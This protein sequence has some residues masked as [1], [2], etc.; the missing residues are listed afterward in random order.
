MEEGSVG[1]RIDFQRNK[2]M[3]CTFQ[4]MSLNSNHPRRIFW[5]ASVE[6]SLETSKRVLPLHYR[7]LFSRGFRVQIKSCLVSDQARKENCKTLSKKTPKLSLS[8]SFP[9]SFSPT[10]SLSFR[11]FLSPS[12]SLSLPPVFFH[13]HHHRNSLTTINTNLF[14]WNKNCPVLLSPSPPLLR[15]RFAVFL[16]FCL[17]FVSYRYSLARPPPF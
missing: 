6:F 16:P 17:S 3:K 15:P 8:L 5:R 7:G 13:L 14:L 2:P 4:G 10:P 11:P 1:E 9:L 12:L